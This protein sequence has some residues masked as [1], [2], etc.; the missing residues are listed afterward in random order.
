MGR[1]DDKGLQSIGRAMAGA[2]YHAY[3]TS[4]EW[5]ARR[6]QWARDEAA[7][8]RALVCWG[9]GRAWSFRRDHLH[10]A[11]YDRLGAEAHED[12]WPLCPADHRELHAV[13]DRPGW[14]RAGRVNGQR[15]ALEAIRTRNGAS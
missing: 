9:C 12:L 4:R 2:R 7:A 3:I 14:G 13:L 1:R 10:H 6:E 5:F 11:T 8:G 15:A